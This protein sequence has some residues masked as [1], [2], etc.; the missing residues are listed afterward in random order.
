MYIRIIA[1]DTNAVFTNIIVFLMFGFLINPLTAQKEAKDSLELQIQILRNREPQN[2][3]N[4]IYVD[5][6][7]ELAK[8]YRFRHADSIKL[9]SDEALF[10]ST[11]I[12]YK[13]GK[14]LALVRIG[15]Y[16]SD[17]GHEEKAFENY[18]ESKEIAFSL[19]FPKLKAQVLK[20]LAF[21]E[22]LS[23][24]LNNAVLTFYEAIDIASQNNLIA[25]EARLR[26]TLGYSY[27]TY[28][29]FD[30]AQLEYLIA[31]SLWNRVPGVNHFKAITISNIALNAMDKGDLDFGN[32]YNEISIDLLNKGNEPLW[33]SRA[34]R[35]KARYFFYKKKFKL[36]R[37]WIRKSDSTLGKISYTRDHM[38]LD[39][40]ES[41]VLL[42]LDSLILA[43]KLIKRVLEKAMI[44]KDSFYLVQSYESLEK[45]E[46]LSGQTESAYAYHKK[47]TQIKSLLKENDKVQNIVL[48]RAKM[49]FVKEKEALRLENFKINHTQQKYLQW[50][51]VG[52]LVSIIISFIMYESNKRDKLLN[53]QLKDKTA[54][55]ESREL[56]LRELNT[57]QEKLFSIVGHD[58]KGPISSLKELLKVMSNENDKEKLL[59]GLLPKLNSYTDHVHFTLNNLLN[60]GKNQM[61]GEGISPSTLHIKS[62]GTN[63]IDL[64]SEAIIK[65]EQIVELNVNEEITAWADKED[66]NV[67]FRN[68]LSNAIKFSHTKGHIKINVTKKE[69]RILLEFADSGI[70]MSKETQRLV[71]DS[72]EHYS[73]FGTNNEK[74]TGLG[75]MLCK[76]IVARNNGEISVESSENNGTTFFVYLP[77]TKIMA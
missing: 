63:V 66:V 56:Q 48:L 1:Q 43:K 57:T 75:L 58:L 33:L 69:N 34:F 47:S 40:L 15:D 72:T 18:N 39:F 65:K 21:Q 54:D 3:Q 13:K 55:L 70:G 41:K 11:K 28:K 32:T 12:G 46:E 59:L 29:L 45:I 9:L 36:A 16:Y 5:L 76:A 19:D 24:N 35:V 7:N 42:N 25:L 74:G 26:H 49:N 17:I 73:T 8:H 22:F 67:I 71:C 20:S 44:N 77:S 64:F 27:Y 23:Q 38:E 68:L 50:I 37:K 62:I 60:W 52:L 51:I 2:L 14:A 10:L 30:E 4:K 31:D 53:K 61:K 6:L